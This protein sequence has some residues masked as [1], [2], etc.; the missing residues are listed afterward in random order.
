MPWRGVQRLDHPVQVPDLSEQG[1]RLMGGR[2]LPAGERPAAL[3]M[4][5]DAKGTRLTLYA[6]P[7]ADGHAGIRY[8]R[9]G[10]VTAFSWAENGLAYA[11]TARID[12]ARLL[13]IAQSVDAQ[14]RGQPHR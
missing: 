6:R 11:V 12:E 2:V 3:L 5:D 10:D 13:T 4:Y 7:G 8:A 14:I 1:F 9:D